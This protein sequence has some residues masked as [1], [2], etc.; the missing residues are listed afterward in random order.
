M[1]LF[2]NCCPRE[3]S[4]T[5]YLA[6]KLL[7]KLGDHEELDLYAEA[8][9]PLTNGSLERRTAL[10]EKGDYSDSMF[11]YAKQFAS[12]NTIVIAAPFWDLSFPSMLKT[13]IENIYV[14]GIVSKYGED[15]I[16]IGLCK[17]SRLYYITTAGGPLDERFGYEY[18]KALAQNAFG[19]KDVTLIKA[20][21]LDIAGNDPQQ[22][23]DA[24]VIPDVD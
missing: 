10:I 6:G 20:E 22:I 7:K 2:I 1:V 17:A 18:I 4:R 5:R 8:L 24:V 11:S 23:L 14:T 12:A 15:G 9:A 3:H 16:P 21:M 19:I 13:Y